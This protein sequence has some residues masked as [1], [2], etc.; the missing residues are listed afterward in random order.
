LLINL[1]KDGFWITR[2]GYKSRIDEFAKRHKSAEAMGG[3]HKIEARRAKGL[4]SAR[5]RIDQL[6]DKGTFK[7]IGKFATSLRPEDL[8]NTPADGKISGFGRIDGRKVAVISNDLTV[9]GASSNDI[10]SKKI[11]HLKRSAIDSGMP[12]VFLAES[13][14][15]RVP[16]SIGAVAMGLGGQDPEQYIRR[17]KVP[18]VT[19]ALGPCYGSSSWYATLSDFVVMRKGAEIAVSSAKVASVA[20]GQEVDPEELGGWRLHTTTTGLVDVAVD[21]DEEALDYVRR[22]LSYMPSHNMAQPPKVAV[23]PGST[24]AAAGILDLVPIE[25]QKTYDV[26]RVIEAIVDQGS[27]FP[28]KP[29]FGKVAVTGLARLDGNTVGVIANNP[30]VK[31]GAMDVNSC[32]KVTSF[33]VLCDS[34]NIPVIL[35]VD[36]PGF[37]IGLEGERNKAPGKI[38]N[39]MQALQ[40]C[41]VP[42]ISVVMRKLYG[43]AFL[44]MGGGRNSDE[45]AAWY[46]GEISFVAPEIGASLIYG[47]DRASDPERYDELVQSIRRDTSAYDLARCFGAQDVIDPRDTRTYLIETL[48]YHH[49][50]ITNGVGQHEMQAWPTTY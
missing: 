31:G 22:Y 21:T 15:G 37:L 3:P 1:Y 47:V 26:R 39:F 17:R 45:V 20:I 6:L 12:L 5:E 48:E 35:L 41:S 29:N 34:F 8:E 9:K 44:N 14:G 13:S 50:D 42:K 16:D 18:W 46:T 2:M 24:E 32:E 28:L 10:N 40:L 30:K 36:T 49:R 4:L 11:S 27:F 25:R 7:E 38:M 19:A 43:Q 33:L 23:P